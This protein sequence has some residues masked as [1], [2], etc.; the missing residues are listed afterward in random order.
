MGE[1]RAPHLQQRPDIITRNASLEVAHFPLC[2]GLSIR[3]LPSPAVAYRRGSATADRRP[4]VAPGFSLRASAAFSRPRFH[5]NGLEVR[6][7]N[8]AVQLKN[9]AAGR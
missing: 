1:L 6:R 5:G 3:R 9:Q 8:G 2:D 7:T 4:R